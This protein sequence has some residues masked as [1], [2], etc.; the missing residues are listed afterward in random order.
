MFQIS[1]ELAFFDLDKNLT[2][3]NYQ[4]VEDIIEKEKYIKPRRNIRKKCY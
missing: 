3:D 1:K 4:I 2:E